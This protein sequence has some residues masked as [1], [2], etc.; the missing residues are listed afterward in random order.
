MAQSPWQAVYVT[1]Q[2]AGLAQAQP[3]LVTVTIMP[4]ETL[5]LNSQPIMLGTVTQETEQHLQPTQ[6]MA[7]GTQPQ[8]SITTTAQQQ[9]LMSLPPPSLMLQQANNAATR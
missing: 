8:A 1:E 4:H 7:D 5:L 3:P 9:S 2:S 6:H